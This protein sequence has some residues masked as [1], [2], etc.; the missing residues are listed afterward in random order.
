M[1]K[2][3]TVPYHIG[4]ADFV[5][6]VIEEPTEQVIQSFDFEEDADEY[7][8]FLNKGGAFDGF[9]PT[10]LLRSVNLKQINSTFQETF[11]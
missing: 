8:K 11:A 9:T 7:C 5:W 1:A 6:C 3:S 10:F 2:Y 4:N